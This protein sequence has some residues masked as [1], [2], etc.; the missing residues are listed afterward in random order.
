MEL[1]TANEEARRHQKV[2]ASYTVSKMVKFC[3]C[4]ISVNTV[5]I[6]LG[7]G[8]QACGERSCNSWGY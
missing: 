3:G 2:C 4:L 5:V 6:V 7:S 8:V 1:K